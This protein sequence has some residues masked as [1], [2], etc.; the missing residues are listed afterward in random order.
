MMIFD[1]RWKVYLGFVSILFGCNENQ[2]IEIREKK[3]EFWSESKSLKAGE[4][5]ELAGYLDSGWVTPHHDETGGQLVWISENQ[6]K[7]SRFIAIDTDFMIVP[8]TWDHIPVTILGV[9]TPS[10]EGES[11]SNKLGIITDME[12]ISFEESK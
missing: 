10:Q 8:G 2:P 6:N 7:G 4:K 3:A 1:R 12:S 5:V 11:P 9:F